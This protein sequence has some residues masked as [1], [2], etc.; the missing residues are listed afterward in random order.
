MFDYL[1]ELDE[2]LMDTIAASQGNDQ[3]RNAGA[4]ST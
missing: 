4:V 2:T 3:G 1:R